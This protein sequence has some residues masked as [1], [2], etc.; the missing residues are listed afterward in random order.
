M[1]HLFGKFMMIAAI[2]VLMSCDEEE[3]PT[4][5]DPPTEADAAFTFQA[6]AESD[7]ILEFTASVDG[8]NRYVWDLGNGESADESATVTGTYSN[9]G[10]YEVTLTVFN[11]GGSASNTQEIEIAETDPTL[12]DNA[13]Y[14]LLTGGV[15]GGGSKTWAVDSASA[16][17]FGVGPSPEN[18]DYDGDYPKYYAA[19]V[20]EKVGA[21]MYNDRYTF[22]LAD[23]GFDMATQGD[24]YL[25]AQQEEQFPDAYDPG[26]G[27]LTAPF[28]P[29]ENLNWNLSF[30]AEGEE[31]D[32]TLSINEDGFIGYYTGVQTYKVVS[33]SEN[34][35]FLQFEDAANADLVWYLRLVPEGFD[36][37]PGG[38]VKATLPIGFETQTPDL[39]SFEGNEASIVE[40]PDQSGI[41][42]SSNVLQLVKGFQGFSGSFFD[43]AEAPTIEEGTTLTLKVWAPVTGVFRIKLENSAGEF[44]EVDA[45]VSVGEEWT[46]LSFDLSAGV[47][48][49]LDRLVLFPSWEV[50][51]T[52]TFYVDDVDVQ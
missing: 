33:I 36:S 47:G 50:P 35:L 6:T 32:T 9:A 52:G 11:D 37:N 7:N 17:H 12:L 48:L 1:K 13:L 42:T 44:V 22:I 20:N 16:G 24:I 5:V 10:S 46:E 18:G 2:F 15:D 40:N 14:N 25:N 19:G 38:S 27:D 29:A 28:T 4:L 23:F 51:S 8:F 41:N 43:L 39:S 34:E 30:P 3:E 26:V 45:D 49:S 21:G 31:G